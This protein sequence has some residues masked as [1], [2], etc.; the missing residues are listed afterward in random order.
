MSSRWKSA[1]IIGSAL[2]TSLLIHARVPPM[3]PSAREPG[4]WQKHEYSFVF[5]GFTST[6]SC[7]RSGRQDKIAADRR[8]RQA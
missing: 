6:Y 8:R 4:V 1:A 3:S 2:L 7:D 5:M